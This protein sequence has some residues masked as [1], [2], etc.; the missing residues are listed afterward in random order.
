MTGRRLI[1]CGLLIAGLLSGPAAAA[2]DAIRAHYSAD[3][4]TC[5]AHAHAVR[6][7]QHCHA[8]EIERQRATLDDLVKR[9]MTTLS[10][11][12][13][14][15]FTAAQADWERATDTKCTPPARRRGSLASQIA[16]AC[17]LE[18]TIV[19]IIAL[20]ARQ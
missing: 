4:A 1:L 12:E 10:P 19:R 13:A 7:T 14:A 2:P 8:L 6:P 9:R 18:E 5:T 17:F 15:G 11:R 3:F 16:Q 20:E